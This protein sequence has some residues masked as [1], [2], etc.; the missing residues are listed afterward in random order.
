MKYHHNITKYQ[1]HITKYQYHIMKYQHHIMKYHHHIT[2]YQHHIMKYHHHIT[3]YHHHITKYHHHIMK[4]HHHNR[5]D[6]IRQLRRSIF[7][8]SNGKNTVYYMLASNTL[9][10]KI[11]Y[12][13]IDTP[14]ELSDHCFISTGL[15]L[16]K[17]GL[18]QQKDL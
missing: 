14:N 3:K 10:H 4:Y 2:K 17:S 7:F 5:V 16:E 18:K 12:F 6:H 9:D 15:N 8:N 13:N 11:V 1:H